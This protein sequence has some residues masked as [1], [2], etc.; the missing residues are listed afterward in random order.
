[1]VL[2]VRVSFILLM[3]GGCGGG[4]KGGGGEGGHWEMHIL[5]ARPTEAKPCRQSWLQPC[6]SRS[7]QIIHEVY[8]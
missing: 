6:C 3:M 7:R 4:A 8:V 1:M 5:H 2:C